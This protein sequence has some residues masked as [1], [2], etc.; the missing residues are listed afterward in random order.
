[1]QIFNLMLACIL[2]L[3][4]KEKERTF[5]VV[6]IVVIA[7]ALLL[8]VNVVLL[9]GSVSLLQ[10]V[11]LLGYCMFP[12]DVAAVVCFC[13]RP[14]RS[15]SRR[16]HRCLPPPG[17]TVRPSGRARSLPTRGT[18]VYMHAIRTAAPASCRML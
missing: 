17:A 12:L 2:S 8:T 13:V 7:G 5:C 10:S 16:R 14:S 4:A 18:G 6:F 1:M 3:D 15:S 11:S 9:G